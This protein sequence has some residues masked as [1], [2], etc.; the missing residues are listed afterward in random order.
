METVAEQASEV[1]LLLVVDTKLASVTAGY[2]SI[3]I[4][5][6]RAMMHEMLAFFKRKKRIKECVDEI[7]WGD[8]HTTIA[9]FAKLKQVDKVMLVHQ[10]NAFFRNLLKYLRAQGEFK[11]EVVRVP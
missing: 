8:T 2:T 6:G 4:S 5:A 11:T 9:N 7:E 3:E 10:D 1:I